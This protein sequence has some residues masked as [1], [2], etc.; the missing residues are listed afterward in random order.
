MR[1]V[2]TPPNG[3]DG[4]GSAEKSAYTRAIPQGG[5][6]RP[7]KKP[8]KIRDFVSLHGGEAAAAAA[9]AWP[10][11][12]RPEALAVVVRQVWPRRRDRRRTPPAWAAAFAVGVFRLA[13]YVLAYLLAHAVDTQKRAAVTL[14][15]T[16]LTVAATVTAR[17]LT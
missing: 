17:L 6:P 10:L 7:Q 1:V 4:R 3:P 13:V 12:D 15:V 16:V 9:G 5:R 14:A 11:T 8:S 2:P